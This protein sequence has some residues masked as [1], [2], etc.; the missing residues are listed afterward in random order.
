MLKYM[1]TNRNE[2][3]HS[4]KL[5]EGERSLVITGTIGII[6]SVGIAIYIF[7]QGPII[8][9]EGNVRDAFSFNAAIGIFILSIAAVLPLTKLG[10]GKRKVVRWF[11]ILSSL[12]SYTIETVQNFRGISPRF[13]REGTAVDIIA[14]MIFG[15]VSLVLVTLAIILALHFFRMKKPYERPLLI[16]GI[17]YAFLSVLAANVAGIWM[18]LLQ[19]RLTG[20]GGNV[21]VLHGLGF[22]ALQTLIVPAWLLEKANV[23]ESLKKRLIHF[24]SIAWMLSI[25]FIG[26]QTAMGR[27]VF[28]LTTFPIL[29]CLFT[30]VCL[31]ITIAA[32]VLL[33]KQREPIYQ[34]FF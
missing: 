15:V 31:G 2:A 3:E 23:K 11:F 17:R 9:P 27:T 12:Y 33:I 10:T 19:D 25:L 20:D 30:L 32:C 14:G 8:S 7:F 13:T 16:I 6:L 24:S 22:H 26:I 28:E 5:F 1:K 21:I 34:R 4:V 29:A 18:I